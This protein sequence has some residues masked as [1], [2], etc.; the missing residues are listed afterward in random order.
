VAFTE[1]LYNETGTDHT[2]DLTLSGNAWD[3]TLSM[4]DTGVL[5]AGAEVSF[6]VWMTIPIGANVG[7]RDPFTVTA[8]SQSDPGT[9]ATA[10]LRRWSRS[11][12]TL[13]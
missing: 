12:G 6:T 2:F 7:D 1:W 13:S 9:S 3:T 8:T 10:G 4:I 5:S 11:L